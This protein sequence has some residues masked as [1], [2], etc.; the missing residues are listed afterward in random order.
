M[1]LTFYAFPAEHWIHIPDHEPGRVDIRHRPAPHEEDERRG[2]PGGVL[3]D[4]M[5]AGDGRAEALESVER[6]S[7][8]RRCPSTV[9]PS[10]MASE[11][12]PPDHGSYTTI[13]QYLK[14][15]Q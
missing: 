13:W 15:R 14:T 2:Q 8:D 10:S 6:V 4:G 3:D 12:K 1:R 7:V 11:R 9:C 5:Q